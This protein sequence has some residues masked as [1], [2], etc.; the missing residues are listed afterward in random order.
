M[1]DNYVMD[2]RTAMTYL[3]RW[4]PVPRRWGAVGI[5]LVGLVCAILLGYPFFAASLCVDL[6][7]A[8][9]CPGPADVPGDRTTML[10]TPVG[11]TVA[12]VVLP[13]LFVGTLFFA[14]LFLPIALL[15][16]MLLGEFLTNNL[17]VV[18]PPKTVKNRME[19]WA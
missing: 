14:K 1:V 15:L 2:C 13:L 4:F 19:A 10:P 12:M 9:K 6:Y 18:L 16:F 11:F 8:Q 17:E 7:L 5:A 3:W